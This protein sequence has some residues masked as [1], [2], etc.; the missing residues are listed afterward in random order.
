[1]PKGFPIVDDS[2]RLPLSDLNYAA[3]HPFSS[4]YDSDILFPASTSSVTTRISYPP[5]VLK[6][7]FTKFPALAKK[8]C[9]LC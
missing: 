6:A 7:L 9:V 4:A 1:M 3:M 2:Y 5:A 8:L